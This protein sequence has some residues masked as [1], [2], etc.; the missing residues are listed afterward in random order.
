MNSS[1]PDFLND[2]FVRRFVSIIQLIRLIPVVICNAMSSGVISLA[3][4]AVLRCE[5]SYRLHLLHLK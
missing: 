3:F 2:M 1:S 5:K 4:A